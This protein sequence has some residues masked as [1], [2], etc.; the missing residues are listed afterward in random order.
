LKN[1]FYLISLLRFKTVDYLGFSD[2]PRLNVLTAEK[3]ILA[4]SPSRGELQPVSVA[5]IFV[6]CR[7]VSLKG[8]FG[9]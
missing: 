4:C 6:N 7:G 5:S 8:K 1:Y 2:P 3:N 9:D